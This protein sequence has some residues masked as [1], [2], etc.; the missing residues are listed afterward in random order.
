MADATAP[1]RRPVEVTLVVGADDDE[2]VGDALRNFL[3]YWLGG[4]P[5]SWGTSGG[6]S[7]GW[8][9][10]AIRDPD[11]TVERYREELDAWFEAQRNR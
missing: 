8:H 3:D 7:F 11:M 6:R 1:P 10:Q 2:R 4:K 5:S 9:Y